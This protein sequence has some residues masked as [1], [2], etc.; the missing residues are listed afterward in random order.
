MSVSEVIRI[1]CVGD[2]IW[3]L[4]M[5]QYRIFG[6][7]AHVSRGAGWIEVDSRFQLS[8]LAAPSVAMTRRC[9]PDI[10]AMLLSSGTTGVP[11]LVQLTHRNLLFVAEGHNQRLGIERADRVLV[12]LPL[13]HASAFVSQF[14]S[15]TGAGGTIV[16]YGEPFF[17]PK[18][19][20]RW[21]RDYGITCCSVVPTIVRLLTDYHHVADHIPSRLRY[22]CCGGD[23]LTQD[24][25][26]ALVE[27]WRNT[28]VVRT[29]GLT[30]SA[31]RVSYLFSEEASFCPGSIGTPL[32]QVLVKI[33]GG[34]GSDGNAE[35]PGEIL[36]SGPNVMP[37][38]YAGC[39]SESKSIIK[40][41]WL[42]T[43]DIGQ[44]NERGGIDFIGRA[45]NTIITRGVNISPEEVEQA[46]LEHNSVYDARVF[47][48]P[49]PVEGERVCAQ[50]VLREC[51]DVMGLPEL[52][53]FLRDRIAAYKFPKL[54]EVVQ[55]I[56]RTQTGKVLR[57]G[58]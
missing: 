15:H 26:E 24:V 6:E 5:P 14:L 58:E 30:E 34:A 32:A 4:S 48:V 19:F 57:Q 18:S 28:S 2:A 40:D 49:D 53:L 39:D 36:V 3:I 8:L 37:G 56:P 46:I 7:A 16:L 35:S 25:A 17:I 54:I 44:F 27:C 51:D 22:L 41:G 1:L 11:K 12:I 43:G 13:F 31:T 10:A 45:K 42:H 33:E 23:V 55:S 50:I 52:H 20:C 29:Y 9:C 21:L 47:G 38:Y